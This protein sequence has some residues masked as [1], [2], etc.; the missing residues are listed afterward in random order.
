MVGWGRVYQ[1]YRWVANILVNPP[2]QILFN[3][4][5]KIDR[6]FFHRTAPPIN[7]DGKR[8]IAFL[9]KVRSLQQLRFILVFERR[10]NIVPLAI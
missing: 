7:A 8:A 4:Y 6:S 1:D 3:I 5:H 9:S 2:L 10:V